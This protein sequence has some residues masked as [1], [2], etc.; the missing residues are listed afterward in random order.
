M[1]NS[2]ATDVGHIAKFDGSNFPSWKYGVWMLLEK[3]RLIS[4]VDGSERLPEQVRNEAGAVQNYNTIDDW[5]QKDV[6]ARTLIYSTNYFKIPRGWQRCR[7]LFLAKAPHEQTVML[8]QAYSEVHSDLTR[9]QCQI[10]FNKKWKTIKECKN[11]S[12]EAEKYLKE[13]KGALTLKRHSPGSLVNLFAKVAAKA[14]TAQSVDAASS[15]ESENVKKNGFKHVNIEFLPDSSQFIEPRSSSDSEGEAIHN[16]SINS[17][18]LSASSTSSKT[19]AQDAIK[20]KLEVINSDLVALYNRRDADMLTHEEEIV[21]KKKKE[22]R[23]ELQNKVETVQPYFLEAII[24]IAMHGSAAQEK[25]R[26][27]IYRSI[28]TLD[29]LTAQLIRDGFDVTR[30]S[31]YFRLKPKRSNSTEGKRHV[32]TV[33]VQLIRAQNDLHKSHPDQGFCK[34]TINNLEQLASLLGPSE[35][36]FLS[37]D[38]KARVAIGIVAAN[39]RAPISMHLE[40]QVQLPDHD[41]VVASGHKLIPSVYAGIVIGANGLGKPEVVGYS[42]D[43]GPDENPRYQKVIETAIHHF[44]KQNFD[45]VFVATNAPGR[46][47]FNRVERRM[48]PLSRELA[49]LILQH[50]HYGSHLYNSGKTTDAELEKKNFEHAGSTIAE[51]WNS[52]IVDGHPI[53]AEYIDPL[54]SELNDELHLN[55][56]DQNWFS[57][58]VMTSQYFLQIVKCNNLSCCTAPRSSYFSIVPS[59]HG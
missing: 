25:R 49:G 42:V 43:G 57:E 2:T 41:W 13:L 31:V 9:Q 54:T 23:T 19:P 1:A 26:S 8:Y 4:I 47:S 18:N 44:K 48:A 45:A 16:S 35:V 15:E 53:V 29:D 14:S 34:A 40:Y 52:V 30:S 17:S 51:V 37:Q 22:E 39:K 32:K 56:A 27:E 59:W 20:A 6:E 5:K 38:D 28:L 24:N 21:F 7:C 36:I 58:H 3:N 10:E 11:R 46:S 55:V 12:E 50:N 33:P